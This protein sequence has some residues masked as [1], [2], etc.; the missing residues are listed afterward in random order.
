[1]KILI[2]AAHADDE[3]IG[4]GGLIRKCVKSGH[5]VK[6]IL[7]SHGNKAKQLEE[8]P[9]FEKAC[10]VLGVTNTAHLHLEDQYFDQYY[11]I[12]EIAAKVHALSDEPD[13]IISHSANDLNKDH[14]IMNEIAKIIGRPKQ[15][16]VSVL[17]MEIG[18]TP[19]WNGKHFS[20]KL[21]VNIS[22]TIADKLQALSHYPT[23]LSAFPY[24]YS[25]KGVG[26]LAQ[27]RG[28]E[29]GYEYAEA[30]QVIRVH[31]EHLSI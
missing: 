23:K 19:A 4:A 12:A 21:Y 18:G 3:T 29:S 2:L 28:M 17:A 16:P 8:L 5:E 20:P 31:G 9:S 13:I 26:I 14:R 7:G 10:S 1:M 24:P 15:K 6:I 25:L 22:D 30:Y 27:A 11:P